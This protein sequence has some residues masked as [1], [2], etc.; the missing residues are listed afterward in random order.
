MQNKKSYIFFI[1]P[2]FTIYT[3]FMI[4]P[5]F[6]AI[7]YSLFSWAGIGPKIF[8]GL[9]NFKKIFFNP[10]IAPLFKNALKNNFVYMGIAVFIF[11]P[12]QVLLAYLIDKR[13]KGHRF[14]KLIIFLPYVISSTIVGFFSLLVFDPNIGCLNLFLEALHL[15]SFTSSWFGD[16]GKAFYLL[17]GVIGWQGIGVGMVIILA[18][19]KSIPEEVIEASIIDGAGDWA[20][21]WRVILPFLKPS[22]INVII[23]SSI[24]AL[25]QFDLPYIIGGPT[26]GINGVMDFMNLF[27]YRYA[28]GDA[29]LGQ[30]AIGFGAS[31]SVVTFVIILFIAVLQNILL[32]SFL[33]RE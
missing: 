33:H 6:S 13:I 17:V 26:G 3:V 2:G 23:L 12:I 14:F 24:Y 21:F 31:I 1:L 8:I 19:F 11:V 16:P 29:Y 7:Y 4:I 18:N 10:Q 32:K 5:L 25:T 28:F 15:N 22:L 27:F 30:T 9:G 20:R